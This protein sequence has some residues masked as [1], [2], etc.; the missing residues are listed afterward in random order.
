MPI[1]RIRYCSVH[2]NGQIVN[3]RWVLKDWMEDR[4]HGRKAGRLQERKEE[5]TTGGCGVRQEETTGI[6]WTGK[7]KPDTASWAME[8]QRQAQSLLATQEAEAT[9]PAAF[10]GR[11]SQRTGCLSGA[12]VSSFSWLFTFLLLSY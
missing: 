11:L 4:D 8:L 7:E 3:A 2:C 6:C 9:G 5:G 10:G 12:R 1:T